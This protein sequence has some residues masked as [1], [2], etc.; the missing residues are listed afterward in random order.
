MLLA[1]QTDIN[2]LRNELENKLTEIAHLELKFEVKKE[3]GKELH[4]SETYLEKI[5]LKH[6]KV[7]DKKDEEIKK[8]N[9]LLN[10]TEK[11]KDTKFE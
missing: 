4:S 9:G 6:R 7:L 8:L 3:E 1:L 10:I 5:I 2:N 11:E